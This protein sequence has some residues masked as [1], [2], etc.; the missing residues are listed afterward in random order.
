MNSRL[1]IGGGLRIHKLGP[2]SVR[3]ELAH[4]PHLAIPYVRNGLVGLYAAAI[5]LLAKNVTTRIVKSESFAPE[6]L[7]VLRIDWG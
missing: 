6:R 5:E 7:L 3:V 4:F 1:C 2:K